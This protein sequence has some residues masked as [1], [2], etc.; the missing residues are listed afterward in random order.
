[1]TTDGPGVVLHVDGERNG[2]AFVDPIDTEMTEAACETEE[3]LVEH[4]HGQETVTTAA[5]VTGVF[6][7]HVGFRQSNHGPRTGQG[8]RDALARSLSRLAPQVTLTG[9][10]AGI[11]A[12]AN[13][14]EDA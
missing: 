14:P 5:S 10:A 3:I 6:G 13:L 4:R 8:R 9:I 7:K 11:Q 2:R 1:M 12:I